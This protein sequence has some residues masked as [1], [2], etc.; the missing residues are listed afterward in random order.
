MTNIKIK[1]VSPDRCI[2]YGEESMIVN[3]QALTEFLKYVLKF[4]DTQAAKDFDDCVAGNCT[5]WDFYYRHS[6]SNHPVVAMACAMIRPERGHV[7]HIED[8]R[9]A[10][11]AV[12]EQIPAAAPDTVRAFK[13]I[14][15]NVLQMAMEKPYDETADALRI[16]VM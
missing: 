2:D 6:K 14:L 9:R 13:D 3:V 1:S 10:Y 8:V 16:T 12:T 11:G 5:E 15:S 7:F 4:A